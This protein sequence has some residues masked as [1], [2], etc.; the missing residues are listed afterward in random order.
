MLINRNTC[1]YI[2]A[3]YRNDITPSNILLIWWRWI[4]NVTMMNLKQW[5]QPMRCHPY[6]GGTWQKSTVTAVVWRSRGWCRLSTGYV[7]STI[8]HFGGGRHRGSHTRQ[9][10]KH[11]CRAHLPCPQSPTAG[12]S[13]DRLSPQLLSQRMPWHPIR[14][15]Q[16]INTHKIWLS[17]T[18][19]KLH[20]P[21]FDC[22]TSCFKGY[23]FLKCYRFQPLVQAHGSEVS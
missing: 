5:H 12:W 17:H 22:I 2:C 7:W 14:E 9:P 19:D 3:F 15:Q 6:R 20:F 21:S 4:S 16:V 8:S 18:N 10:C 23:I 13:G 11:Q 1:W